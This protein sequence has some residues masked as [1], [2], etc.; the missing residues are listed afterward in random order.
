MTAVVY[1]ANR[2]SHRYGFGCDA[3]GYD[4]MQDPVVE[5][6]GLDAAWFAD[7]DARAPGLYSV[8]RQTLA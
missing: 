5:M 3:D 4:P 1:L 8:A 7:L 2:L 6:L